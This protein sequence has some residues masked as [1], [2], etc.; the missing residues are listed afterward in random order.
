MKKWVLSITAATLI[1]GLAACNG[2]NSESEVVVE[3]NAGNITENELYEKLKNQYGDMVLYEMVLT[4]V[5]STKYGV[6]E[7]DIDAEL[8]KV[9]EQYGDQFEVYLSMT[10]VKDEAAYK[11]TLR[12][13]VVQDKALASYIEIPE[14]EMKKRY[15][16]MKP[17]I[18]A[19]HIL[20]KDENKAKEILAKVQAGEDFAALATENSEDTASAV[21]G[22]DLGYFGPGMMT[23][24]FEEAAYA[25]EVGGISDLVKSEFGYH[26]IKLTDR[27]DLE[28]YE[29]KKE[30]IRQ[31]IIQE[32]VEKDPTTIQEK[33]KNDLK[34][35]N[36]KVNDEDLQ[37]IFD[38]INDSSEQ[39]APDE[40][41]DSAES[42]EQQK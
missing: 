16:E 41:Q 10:G 28:P 35:A 33:V 22:G 5:L 8:A 1:F 21:N 42:T 26:I 29:E 13:Q 40:A 32:K 3:T 4:K 18:K 31:E 2:N 20:I 14:E 36:I 30:E 11:D 7:E 12:M 38:F 23:K 15:E 27:K 25:L 19:S 37:G 24:P 9:K 39:A 34:E 17:E 6:T